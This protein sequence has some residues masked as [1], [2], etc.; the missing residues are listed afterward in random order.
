MRD[1]FFG[2][3][4]YQELYDWATGTAASCG[5]AG[6][7]LSK[8]TNISNDSSSSASN[9]TSDD[10]VAK[11]LSTVDDAELAPKP[12]D[13]QGLEDV[14][15]IEGGSGYYQDANGRWHRPN[16]Q[17]ASNA[18]MGIDSPTKKT[19]GT[20]GNSLSDPR[21]N[22]GYALVDKDTNEIL[23]FGETL[24]PDSRYSQAFLNEN[25][26]KMVIMEQGSKADIH[27]WQHDLNMYYKYKYGEFPPLNEGGW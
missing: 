10:V 2:G 5:Y 16:G 3:E 24:Y 14:D 26:A 25:N 4:E 19:I 27:Y 1:T 7:A 15:I 13:V 22:Y 18:E 23:K 6:Y 21:T 17:F 20:H 8:T 11:E 9:I 12:I